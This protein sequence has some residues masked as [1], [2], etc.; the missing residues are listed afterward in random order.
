MKENKFGC[1]HGNPKKA[2]IIRDKFFKDHPEMKDWRGQVKK[3]L[4]E[5]RECTE[6]R[7]L[8]SCIDSW[9]A[10]PAYMSRVYSKVAVAKSLLY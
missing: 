6:K 2:A 4:G 9:N 10:H 7:T 1:P 8:S 5:M 3:Y